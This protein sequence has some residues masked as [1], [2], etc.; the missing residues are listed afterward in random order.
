MA[1][2]PARSAPRSASSGSTLWAMA[3]MVGAP[4]SLESLRLWS[5]PTSFARRLSLWMWNGI[6]SVLGW[7][8]LLL[9]V[10]GCLISQK[11][12][13]INSLRGFERLFLCMACAAGIWECFS[14]VTASALGS[15]LWLVAWQTSFRH[16]RRGFKPPLG[17]TG[18]IE[19]SLTW[20]G[21]LDPMVCGLILMKVSCD[22]FNPTRTPSC[23]SFGL[24]GEGWDG[25]LSCVWSAGIAVSSWR[26]RF[27]LMQLATSE[28]LRI[29][30][31]VMD[32]FVQS[33]QVLLYP[34]VFI[35]S[36]S[37]VKHIQDVFGVEMRRSILL[38]IIFV[39]LAPG[40]RLHGPQAEKFDLLQ[41][42]L[43]WRTCSTSCSLAHMAH[44]RCVVL[45][46]SR[47]NVPEDEDVDDAA[48]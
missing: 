4:L 44:V 36:F 38:G 18:F 43:G 32:M 12:F 46:A 34:I 25:M 10:G 6:C 15:C 40:L 41:L 39:G 2:S 11:S 27:L 26:N 35:R 8:H 30:L 7:F 19:L 33:W 45:A 3:R 42:R 13:S 14:K 48:E 16:T 23:T 29:L 28:L 47:L 20:A 24:L 22:C 9:G 1:S 37:T 5:W 21:H 31:Q 17:L